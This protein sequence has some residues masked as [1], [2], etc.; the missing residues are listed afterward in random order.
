ME[1]TFEMPAS[2]EK[3]KLTP[4]NAREFLKDAVYEIDQKDAMLARCIDGRYS[5]TEAKEAPLARPGA[6][7]GYIMAALAA[8]NETGGTIA[9]EKAIDAVIAAAGGIENI[10]VHTDSHAEHDPKKKEDPVAGCGHCRL[11]RE[12]AQKYGLTESD[13]QFVIA[14]CKN[15]VA[16]GAVDIVLEGDHG[17]AAIFIVDSKTHSVRAKDTEGTQAFIYQK[18]LDKERLSAIARYLAGEDE[19]TQNALLAALEKSSAAQLALTAEALASGLPVYD[20]KIASTGAISFPS[21]EE[22]KIAA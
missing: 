12:M 3:R 15:L 22:V 1:K 19:K 21:A 5:A 7:A 8:I 14:A 4:E 9:K 10:R 20:I 6:D 17:E 18:T 16:E 2:S 13:A 11:G